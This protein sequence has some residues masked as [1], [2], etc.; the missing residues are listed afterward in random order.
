MLRFIRDDRGAAIIESAL[1]A[2]MLAAMIAGATDLSLGFS[3]KLKIQQAATRSIELATA[4]GLN[5]SAFQTLQA[6]AANA[7]G[8]PS[9][10]VTVDRW[11][12]CSGVRQTSFSGTCASGQLVARF[13]SVRITDSY[14]PY[15]GFVLRSANMSRDG[16]IPISGY[17][18][19]R[20]Q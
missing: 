2:P 17:A 18:A 6:D 14:E 9:T 19:V 8:V 4:A 7:A 20:V 1:V 16:S 11:L 10:Q 3:Q 15:F 13:V 12:E 5:S